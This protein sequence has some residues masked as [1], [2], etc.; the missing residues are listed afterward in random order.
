MLSRSDKKLSYRR[1]TAIKSAVHVYLVW[2]TDHTMH[3][4]PQNRR[5][6]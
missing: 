4:T 5:C 1:E 3:R 2:L 6:T